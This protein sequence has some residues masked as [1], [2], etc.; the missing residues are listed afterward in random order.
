MYRKPAQTMKEIKLQWNE[1]MEVYQ[2]QGY[3]QK[4]ALNIKEE[5]SKLADLQYL[6]KQSP[7][8]LFTTKEEVKAYMSNEKD[9]D[10]INKRLFIEVRYAG[11]HVCP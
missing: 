8:G 1:Q 7:P 2:H 6:K 5:V 3:S 10:V 9:E 4:E 11:R